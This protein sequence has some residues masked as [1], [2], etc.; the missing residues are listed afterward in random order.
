MKNIASPARSHRSRRKEK[1][2]ISLVSGKVSSGTTAPLPLIFH[3]PPLMA[4]SFFV[5]SS[6]TNFSITV[7]FLFWIGSLFD[8]NAFSLPSQ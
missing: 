7:L 8:S 6:V 3:C 1:K 4:L 2:G 5:L